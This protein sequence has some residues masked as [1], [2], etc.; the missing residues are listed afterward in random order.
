MKRSKKNNEQDRYYLQFFN[1]QVEIFT[2]G[3][4]ILKGKFV[5]WDDN[6]GDVII[7]NSYEKDGKTYLNN[8]HI[9]K[10]LISEIRLYEQILEN[11]EKIAQKPQESQKEGFLEG[12]EEKNNEFHRKQGGGSYSTS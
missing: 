1:K 7:Q 10:E 4:L 5:D 8:N 2:K 12:Y 3:G 6:E 9:E 11:E